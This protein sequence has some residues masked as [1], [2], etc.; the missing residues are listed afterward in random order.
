VHGLPNETAPEAARINTARIALLGAAFVTVGLAIAQPADPL[1]L[2][3]WAV[4]L[5]AGA[6]FPVL[7][8]AI[9]WKRTNA[10]G[11]LAAM[12]TGFGAT[13]FFLLLGEMGVWVWPGAL[14]GAIGLVLGLAAGVAVSLATPVPGRH[15]LDAV[16]ELRVP[17]G[18]T[19]YDRETRLQRLKNRAT[20]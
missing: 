9:W 14:G 11:A 4:T 19:L 13:V 1:Q 20:T 17:G 3:L 12:I 10:M 8:L 7:L 16:R 15:V 18:E 6:S 5:S 2:F